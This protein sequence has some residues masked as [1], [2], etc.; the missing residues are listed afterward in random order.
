MVTKQDVRFQRAWARIAGLMYLLVLVLD[1]SGMQLR[2]ASA[3]RPLLLAGSVL[4]IPL[5]LGLYYA[6]RPVQHALALSALGFRLVEAALG[7]V[8]TLIGFAGV[9]PELARVSL[10]GALLDLARWDDRTA[11]AA[12]VFTIGSITFFYLFV[13]SVYI[14]R[15]LSWLGLFASILAFSACLAHLLRPAFP[16]TIVYAWLPMLLAE[17]STG[18]WLSIRSLRVADGF[19]EGFAGADGSVPLHVG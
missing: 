3:S 1:L 6:L 18:L 10:G 5:A 7:I 9:Q 13:R 8:S 12:F 19:E 14:P 2:S 16:A 4:T 17:T 11:F 15:I